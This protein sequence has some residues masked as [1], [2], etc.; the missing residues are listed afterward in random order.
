MRIEILG[1]GVEG[2][3]ALKFL[4]KKYPKVDFEV[5]DVK[6][7]GKNYLK[8]LDKFNL[9]VRSPG[10]S[11]LRP[12]IQKA[13]KQGIKITSATKL[14]FEHAK[15]KIIGITGTKGKGTVATMLYKILKATGKNVYLAG[16]IG[17][18]M[19]DI[20]LKLQKNS[21]TILELSS[22]QLQDL[23]R[24]PQI[25]VI[26]D[27]SPDHLDYHKSF[28]EYIDAKTNIARFQKK[29][30]KVFYFP[31]NRYSKLIA[32]RG[33]GKKIA[34]LPNLNLILKIPGNHNI[35]NASMAAA[36]GRA[37]GAKDVINKTLSQ[38]KGLPHRLEFLREARG[39]KYYNDSA[40]TNPAATVA[41]VK[42]FKEPKILL[43]GGRSKGLNFKLLK[44]VLWR[45]NVRLA[46][47]FGK[48]RNEIAGDI[49]D[50]TRILKTRNLK[51]AFILTK[52]HSRKG[53][54]VLLSPASASFDEFSGYRERGKYFK[55]L[56]R[57][58]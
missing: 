33:R 28:R 39:I 2:K 23:K 35:K 13:R 29:N 58:L 8:D 34:I 50:S 48:N 11:Y 56:V 45:G 6:K 43:M 41:A 42:S 54:I 31:D 38:F 55:K 4:K 25:A 53:D 5:R 47:L 57:A 40:S 51:S 12:E 15:G 37:F 27:I 9:I 32:S 46:I 19:L 26:L 36:V 3:S 10:I 52:K 44:Q 1:Y 17:R 21:I 49:K 18:P 20:L 24:S 14:F 16:N 7:L 22:F 30:H